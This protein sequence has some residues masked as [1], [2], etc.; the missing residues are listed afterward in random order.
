M[1]YH[2]DI[3]IMVDYKLDYSQYRSHQT[4]RQ[5]YLLSKQGHMLKKMEVDGITAEFKPV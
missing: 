5:R 2:L 4:G 3:L 1:N